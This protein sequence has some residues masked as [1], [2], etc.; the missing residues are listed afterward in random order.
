MLQRRGT[1]SVILTNMVRE[2][3]EHHL[4]RLAIRHYFDVFSYNDAGN[5]VLYGSV[6]GRRLAQLINGVPPSEVCLVGDTVEEIEIARSYGCTSIA[7]SA[8][9]HPRHRLAA[10]KPTHLFDSYE[11]LLALLQ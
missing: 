2:Y 7:I 11:P 1:R 6:K 10:A 9:A 5:Q 4:D 3:V 8:G